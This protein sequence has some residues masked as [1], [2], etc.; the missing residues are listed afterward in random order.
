[1][2]IRQLDLMNFRNY[3][4]LSLEPGPGTNILYGDNAQGKTNILESIYMCGAARSHRASRDR[5]MIRFDA[6]EAHIKMFVEKHESIYRLDMHLKKSKTKG[7]A[8]NGLPIRK[9]S[10]LFGIVNIIFFS[11]EDLNLVKKGPAERRRFIDSEL[12][13]LDKVYTSQLMN[14]NKV[15]MERNRLLKDMAFSPGLSDTLSVW[16]EQLA[17]FGEKIIK[18]R[19]GFVGQLND[20][21]RSLHYTLTGGKETITLLYEPDTEPG[22]FSE[23]LEES[24][25]RDMRQRITSRGP[26]RDDIC[27]LVNGIDIRKYGSQ[28]QQR[29]AALSLKLSEIELVRQLIHD[30]PV[31]L[32]DD[33]LSEL[34]SSRQTQLL[35]AIKDTQTFITCTGLDEFVNCR[36]PIDH[37]FRV[38]DGRVERQNQPDIE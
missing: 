13:Q 9:V 15:L 6:E 4:T 11:P 10:E 34:D 36:F 33:V 16:D 8:V 28:G 27:F 12:C 38:A 5:E 23:A 26:H 24:L 35:A 3:E 19:T 1:M 31:L 32:L 37:L 25:D 29:T 7:I 22:R 30:T 17:E 2:K 18:R 21:I 20:I 14:Y